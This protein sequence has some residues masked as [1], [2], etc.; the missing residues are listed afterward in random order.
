MSEKYHIPLV[1]LRRVYRRIDSGSGHIDIVKNADL[2]VAVGE[3]LA[4]IGASGSGKSSI[5]E[6][7]GTLARPTTGT[8]LIN[9]SDVAMMPERAVLQLRRHIIGFVFQSANLIDHLTAEANV[10]LP[11]TYAGLHRRARKTRTLHWLDRVGVAHLASRPVAKLSGGE[12]QRVAI[13]R[14]LVNEPALILADEPTGNLDQATGQKIMSLLVSLAGQDRTLITVTHDTTH[15]H[16]FDR[17]AR[18]N[19]GHLREMDHVKAAQGA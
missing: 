9:G 2:S 6:L 4:I 17:V 1:A 3:T 19:H 11:L 16:L 7:I 15:I 13:A 8:V 5:L 18:M 14:A 10:T 12:R